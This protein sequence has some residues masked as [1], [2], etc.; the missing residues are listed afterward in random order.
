MKPQQQYLDETLEAIA[1][2]LNMPIKILTAPIDSEYSKQQRKM[3]RRIKFKRF[4][5]NIY[6]YI[7]K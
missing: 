1:K 2:D 5:V 7:F 6:K 3:I 4:F